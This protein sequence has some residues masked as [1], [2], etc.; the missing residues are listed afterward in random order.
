MSSRT[1]YDSN[2]NCVLCGHNADKHTNLIGRD[3][4]LRVFCNCC[5]PRPT[6]M[7]GDEGTTTPM[8]FFIEFPMIHPCWERRTT[9]L[10]NFLPPSLG[11]LSDSS[12]AF[13]GASWLANPS[14]RRGLGDQVDPTAFKYDLYFEQE[15]ICAGCGRIQ[16]FD[17]I[18]VDHIVPRSKG[19]RDEV[20]NLQLLCPSC[21]RI[22]GDR[23]MRHLKTELK[24]RGRMG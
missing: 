24:R 13:N 17:I 11:P 19:G 12:I 14:E 5:P 1:P 8:P 6:R 20:G 16:S 3:G 23:D 2:R 4:I 21:N 22:K 7:I 9:A 10:G 15:G 18:E